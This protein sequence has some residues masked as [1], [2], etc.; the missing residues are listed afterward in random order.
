MIK[1]LLFAHL[2]EEIGKKEI[3]IDAAGC[4]VLQFKQKLLAKYP[5]LPLENVLTAINEEY[6]SEETKL[7]DGDVVAFI[8][9]VSGG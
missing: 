4:T 9:P 5:N 3:E 2:S 7:Q 8:P 1:V 6:M